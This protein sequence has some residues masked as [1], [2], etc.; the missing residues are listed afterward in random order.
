MGFQP[1]PGG[2]GGVE[3]G[4]GSVLWPFSFSRMR[5]SCCAR[6]GGMLA[7]QSRIQVGKG[8]APLCPQ[9]GSW[10]TGASWLMAPGERCWGAPER[11]SHRW[12]AGLGRPSE[13]GIHPWTSTA[14][15]W[16]GD[17]GSELQTEPGTEPQVWNDGPG[18]PR[19]SVAPRDCLCLSCLEWTWLP[20]CS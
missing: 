20:V 8:S 1:R 13:G 4:Q 6:L 16:M 18:W 7:R 5:F 14:S 12:R 2:G 19:R 9:A 10:A 3:A 17:R 11:H 15:M